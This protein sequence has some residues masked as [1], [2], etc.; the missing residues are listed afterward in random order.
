MAKSAPAA[1]G[2][3]SIRDS[4]VI[5]DSGSLNLAAKGDDSNVLGSR[6]KRPGST[7]GSGKGK[8]SGPLIVTTEQRQEAERDPNEPPKPLKPMR[9][10][11]SKRTIYIWGAAQ[12]GIP[13]QVNALASLVF[14]ATLAIVVTTTL[15]GQRRRRA[16]ESRTG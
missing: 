1:P 2:T 4:G 11:T 16:M 10:G 5:R 12:R 13:V 6:T 8:S 9:R 15:V 7:K 3:P 14:L